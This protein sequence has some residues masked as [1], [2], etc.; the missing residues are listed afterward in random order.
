[1]WK[2]W[3]LFTHVR[4]AQNNLTL[5]TNVRFIRVSLVVVILMLQWVSSIF[6]L[7]LVEVELV[8][9]SHRVQPGLRVWYPQVFHRINLNGWEMIHGAGQGEK[10]FLYFF[11]IFYNLLDKG[12]L[13]W[14]SESFLGRICFIQVIGQWS[15]VLSTDKQKVENS[16]VFHTFNH[17][18]QNQKLNQFD[19]SILQFL[20]CHF[21]FSGLLLALGLRM[22]PIAA[23]TGWGQGTLQRG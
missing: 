3:A 4:S 12:W 13:K 17:W 8:S 10:F 15:Q 7:L 22:E 14:T 16:H 21:L 18:P 5:K 20:L 2:V 9:I 1:M 6:L 19:T 23:H 11:A